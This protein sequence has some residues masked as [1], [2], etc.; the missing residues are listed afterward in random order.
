VSVSVAGAVIARRLEF[1]APL[2]AGL[3]L[4]ALG[5]FGFATFDASTPDWQSLGF[6]ALIG[7]G[8]GPALSGLQIA[9]Q[10]IVPPAAIG[11]ATGTLMLLRQIGASIA[12]AAATVLYARGLHGGR[13]D[14]DAA[15]ATGHAVFLVALAG[16]VIAAVALLALPRGGGRLPAA[17]FGRAEGAGAGRRRARGRRRAVGGGCLK[18]PRD[19]SPRRY[20]ARPSRCATAAAC[21]RVRTSSLARMRET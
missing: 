13:G 16:A 14:T 7:V 20:P 4:S 17:A 8:I 12:I 19:A 6:M 18:R 10:R 21:V 3:A 5:A 11:A 1:R 9:I 15:A 2:L